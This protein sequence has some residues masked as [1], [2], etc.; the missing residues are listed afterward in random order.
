MSTLERD[1]LSFLDDAPT[2]DWGCMERAREQGSRI[3]AELTSDKQTLRALLERTRADDELLGMCE[4]HAPFDKLVLYNGKERGF[5]LRLHVWN[6]AEFE[7]AHQHRFSFT[8]RLLC[9]SYK[10]VIYVTSQKLD[11]AGTEAAAMASMDPDHPDAESGIDVGDIQPAFVTTH[12]AGDTY[13]L[14]HS[15]VHAT[16]PNPGTVSLILRGPAEKS[17]AVVVDMERRRVYWR[18]GRSDEGA[19]RI[20]QKR[21]APA[22]FD[23]VCDRLGA[24]G[25]A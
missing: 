14:H 13:T 18:F 22:E 16:F 4:R 24:L 15:A 2:L 9:G 6:E 3:L 8:T 10:H 12:A 25:I 17:H 19:E 5:R 20:K 1:R 23:R 21:M 11:R 7:R